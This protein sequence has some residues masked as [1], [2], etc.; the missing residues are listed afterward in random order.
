M[1]SAAAAACG[2]AAGVRVRVQRIQH[3]ENVHAVRTLERSELNI[4][5]YSLST[6]RAEYLAGV[7]AVV[8][9]WWWWWW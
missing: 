6:S 7:A 5:A 3:A 4:L 9:R 8:R 2:F 1:Y